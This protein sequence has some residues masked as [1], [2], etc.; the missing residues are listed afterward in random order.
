MPLKLIEALEIVQKPAPAAA[1]NF[2]AALVCGFTPLHLEPLLQANLSLSLP[3]RKIEIH[4]GIFGDLIG[5]LRRATSRSF[6]SI[7]VV[8]EWTDFD[9]RLGF[10]SLG[11][12]SPDNFPAILVEV[13]ARSVELQRAIRGAAVRTPVTICMPT[14][15]FPPIS[16]CSGV[17]ASAIETQIE[18]T[19][20][21]LASDLVEIPGVRL[22]NRQYL[23]RVSPA[24]QRYA[25][26]SDLRFGFPYTS[27]HAS[28][29]AET[30]SRLAAPDAPKKGI[31]TD[32]DDTLWKGILGEDGVERVTWTLDGGGAMHGAYQRLLQSLA[33]SGVMIA[34]ASKNDAA[35]VSEAFQRMDLAL[36]AESIY[37]IEAH[38]KEKSESVRRILQAWNVSAADV[39]LVDDNAMELAEVKARHPEMECVLFPKESNSQILSLLVRLRELFGKSTSQDEDRIRLQSI[40]RANEVSLEAAATDPDAFLA[41]AEAHLTLDF[42]TNPRHPRVLELVNKTNQFNL[43]GKRHMESAWQQYFEDPNSFLLVADYQ[44]KFG[45][46]GKIA[47][48]AGRAVGKS[49]FVDTWVMSCRAFSR[50]IEYGYLAALLQKF[51]AEE[52]EFAF[53]P[54]PRNRPFTDFLAT[55]CGIEPSGPIRLTTEA[56]LSR[57]PK[58]YY[59][60]KGVQ[61]G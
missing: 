8:S 6:D 28:W 5:N 56:V 20:T 50:R 47:V 14:V 60:I 49:L 19:I 61:H 13:Q 24:G 18:L 26:D 27:T 12:W 38:W 37:P 52:V 57:A 21:Q 3:S 11:S 15:P 55:M 33:D 58:T 22:A 53:A 59:E 40:R 54:T 10:R 44:D 4:T 23:D 17:Q 25:V 46:L 29:L 35:L 1:E 30:I 32:L 36:R 43:N 31:I 48:A 2:S 45:P 9:A 41:S 7:V 16:L 51:D 34:V 42:A 39:V